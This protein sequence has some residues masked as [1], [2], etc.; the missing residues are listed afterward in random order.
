MKIHTNCSGGNEII[1]FPVQFDLKIIMTTPSNHQDNVDSLEA[2]LRN[3]S[4]DFSN[5]RHKISDKG[6]YTSY[7]V[8]VLIISQSILTQLYTDLKNV[9]GVKLAL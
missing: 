2:V 9:P 8:N 3:L 7:T 6:A 1:K 5:W 4:I